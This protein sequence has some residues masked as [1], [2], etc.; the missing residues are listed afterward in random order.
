MNIKHRASPEEIASTNAHIAELATSQG[1]DVET[2]YA[3]GD[4][5]PAKRIKDPSVAKELHLRGVICVLC[6][7]W[8]SLHHIYPRG[9]GGD[10]VTANLVGLCGDGVSGHHG[11]IEGGDVVTRMALGEYISDHR[12]DT[13]F[14]VQQKLG[15]EE[16]REWMRQKF[17][18]PL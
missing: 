17:Y 3:G 11:L 18:M 14:Y 6:G 4:P 7:N 5:K 1:V 2:L 16:G 15:E 13:V 10:D 9:Q 12:A 8:G